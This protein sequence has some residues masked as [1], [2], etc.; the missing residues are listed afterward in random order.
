MAAFANKLSCMRLVSLIV[1]TLSTAGVP[2]INVMAQARTQYTSA[3]LP[4]PG[5]NAGVMPITQWSQAKLYTR[6]TNQTP[7]SAGPVLLSAH[8]GLWKYY[9][10]NVESSMREAV[11]RGYE[12]LEVDVRPTSDHGCVLSHDDN[13]AKLTN[14]PGNMTNRTE[15]DLRNLSVRH[16]QGVYIP[17]RTGNTS[18]NNSGQSYDH[19]LSLYDALAIMDSYVKPGPG[20]P[21]FYS[22][23]GQA[24]GPLLMIDVKTHAGKTPSGGEA[25]VVAPAD[26]QADTALLTDCTQEVQNYIY[27]QTHSGNNNSGTAIANAIIFKIIPQSFDY[28]PAVLCQPYSTS[29]TYYSVERRIIPVYSPDS[30][31]DDPSTDSRF[32]EFNK[33]FLSGDGSSGCVVAF[34]FFQHH[35]SDRTDAYM[36]YL[37][38]ASQ[39]GHGYA[40]WVMPSFLPEGVGY[41]TCCFQTFF[42]S[43]DSAVFTKVGG[44][45]FPAYWANTGFGLRRNFTM[46]TSDQVGSMCSLLKAQGLRMASDMT[47]LDATGRSRPSCPASE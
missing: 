41:A 20:T 17:Q 4:T 43:A 27:D 44:P 19:M 16:H 24:T 23:S 29:Q 7:T 30:A 3:Q 32:L 8:R 10:E 37:D 15:S 42:G 21:V 9:P 28:N 6:L 36:S 38:S 45:D 34:E 14:Y 18:P 46:E 12:I 26:I 47:A 31:T 35:S 1:V 33:R 11:E 22:F 2:T 25:V 39:A 40:H 5:S 13:L